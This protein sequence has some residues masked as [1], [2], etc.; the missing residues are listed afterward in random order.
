VKQ[1]KL[2]QKMYRASLSQNDKKLEELR[3]L[4]FEKIIDRKAKGK[5]FTT[6]WTLADGL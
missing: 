1:S 5:Q 6:K 4:E 3:K 2:I